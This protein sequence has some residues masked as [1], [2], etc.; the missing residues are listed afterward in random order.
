[1]RHGGAPA[2]VF[3]ADQNAI[4]TLEVT[5]GGA[6]AKEL[7]IRDHGKVGIGPQFANDALDGVA[8]TD[9]HGRFGDDDGE[10]RQVSGD[11]AGGRID[12]REIGEAVAPARRRTH[13]DEDYIS[14]GDRGSEIRGE[15]QSPSRHIA[16]DQL[17]EARLVNRHLATL[18]C[19]DAIFVLIDAVDLMSEIGE[20][21]PRY[22]PDIT[23]SDHRQLHGAHSHSIRTGSRASAVTGTR[24]PSDIRLDR[25]SFLNRPYTLPERYVHCN[26]LFY[27]ERCKF[28]AARI[29]TKWLRHNPAIEFRRHICPI[30]AIIFRSHV[31]EQRREPWLTRTR[32][33]ELL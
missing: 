3:R 11:F 17:G 23:R 14:C 13:S 1:M 10:S 7:G 32:H 16:G 22:Q 2:V 12:V 5:D 21:R 25:I 28:C 9:R 26:K 4:G 30:P 31:D 19:R 29:G 15:R 18:E 6:L 33:I 8:G 24:V 27:A 20:T